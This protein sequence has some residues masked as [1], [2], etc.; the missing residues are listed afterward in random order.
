MSSSKPVE[1]C[2]FTSMT[3]WMPGSAL[4]TSAAT[5]KRRLGDGEKSVYL[6][7]GGDATLVTD[8]KVEPLPPNYIVG[9]IEKP[10]A[11]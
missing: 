7:C 2:T 1:I 8:Q 6:K 9:N 3:Y 5:G 11:V 10:P 4:K